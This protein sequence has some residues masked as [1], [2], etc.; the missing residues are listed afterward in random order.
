MQRM[1]ATIKRRFPA[2]A[3][4]VH[5][6]KSKVGRAVG[7]TP[8]SMTMADVFARIYDINYWGLSD[9]RSGPGSDLEQTVV[10]RAEIPK[11]IEDL[12]I[13]SMLDIPCGDFF[14][15]RKCNVGVKTYIGADIV[16]SMIRELNERYGNAHRRFEVL[17]LSIDALPKVRPCALSRCTRALFL[18]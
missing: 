17:D 7:S 11:L 13:K 4:L 12:R 1:K 16:P 10:I 6:L 15:M 3:P 14:W 2:L 5:L 18:E 9:S 8:N